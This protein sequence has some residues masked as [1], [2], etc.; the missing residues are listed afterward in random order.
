MKKISVLALLAL[1]YISA[2]AQ[3]SD[4]AEMA[5]TFRSSGKIGL[6]GLNILFAMAVLKAGQPWIINLR[7]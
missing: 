6:N 4:A 3:K 7:Y 2:F 5:D 1:S